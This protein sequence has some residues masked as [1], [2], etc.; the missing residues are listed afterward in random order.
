MKYLISL[1]VFFLASSACHARLGETEDQIAAR[2]GKPTDTFKIDDRL[3]NKSF[4]HGGY[5]IQVAFLDGKSQSETYQAEAAPQPPSL[6][7]VVA[8]PPGLP[9]V[10]RRPP[11][12]PQMAARDIEKYE[13]QIL[14]DANALGSKWTTTSNFVDTGNAYFQ[15]GTTWELE[16]KAARA[17]YI[18]DGGGAA[19]Q[20]QSP[21]YLDY[22][23][24][25][26]DKAVQDLENER[27]KA[28]QDF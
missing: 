19:V 27:K 21:I 22:L 17:A 24:Q 9:E 11:V 2:Y 12:R 20:I 5:K 1:F 3:Q 25:K 13:V 8:Q 18:N 6:P 15:I 28:L 14:L 26:N 10:V 4:W 16:S 23:K 7:Q